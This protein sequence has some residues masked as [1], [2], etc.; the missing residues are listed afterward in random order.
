MV[1]DE[2]GRCREYSIPKSSGGRRTI[3][4]PVPSLMAVQRVIKEAIVDNISIHDAAVGFRA[5][6][7]IKSHVEAHLGASR[8]IKIDIK[9]CFSSIRMSKIIQIFKGADFTNEMSYCLARLATH[10]GVLPQG[11]PT[12]PGLCNAVLKQL[13]IRLFGLC[14]GLNLRYSRYSDDVLISGERIDLGVFK[15]SIVCVE[16]CA[17]IVNN[18]T[19]MM[20]DPIRLIVCGISI[21]G[22]EMKLPK[23][24]KREIRRDAYFLLKK[25]AIHESQFFK[26]FDPFYVD[27]I[28]GRLGF[29]AFVEPEAEFPRKYRQFIKE[30]FQEFL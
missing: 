1:M 6:Y 23:N 12:S 17:L 21:A 25:G 10:R 20:I 16:E 28:L 15:S 9:D 24:K 29:W 8:Y 5:G 13:D 14:E 18:K 26:D 7:S 27:R 22:G 3:A 19:R 2:G 4:V 30:Q 11:A